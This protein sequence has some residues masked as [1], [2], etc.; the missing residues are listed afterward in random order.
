MDR[1]N[2]VRCKKEIRSGE[3]RYFSCQAG[4]NGWYHWE[5]FVEACRQANK[6]GASE[7]ETIALSTGLYNNL[8]SYD[9]IDDS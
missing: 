4:M 9:V 2:C 8:N 5:C 1:C 3:R 6:I 7:I